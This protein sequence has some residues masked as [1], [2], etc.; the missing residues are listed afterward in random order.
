MKLPWC[1]PAADG[2]YQLVEIHIP[3][4]QA[5]ADAHGNP[6]L[7][8]SSA[9]PAQS[10]MLAEMPEGMM[11]DWHPPSRRQLAVI[12]SGTAEV[13]ASDGT[14]RLLTAGQILV[15]DDVGSR[16]HRTR[17]MGGPVRVLFVHL[18]SDADIGEWHVGWVER[19]EAHR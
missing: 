17:T 19:S 14:K 11:M 6:V 9:L 4:Y 13:E 8:C 16:G 15:A 1:I 10:V 2:G 3:V 12:L 5:F 18:P 7:H